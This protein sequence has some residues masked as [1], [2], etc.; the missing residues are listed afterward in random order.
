MLTVCSLMR[1]HHS[2][3]SEAEGGPARAAVHTQAAC[4]AFCCTWRHRGRRKREATWKNGENCHQPP[5]KTNHLLI[6]S[7]SEIKGG[8]QLSGSKHI[9]KKLAV[10]RWKILDISWSS[11][12]LPS[13]CRCLIVWGEKKSKS[14]TVYLVNK[15]LFIGVCFGINR[16]HKRSCV[17]KNKSLCAAQ[18]RRI[19]MPFHYRNRDRRA[20]PNTM[21][22]RV[23]SFHAMIRKHCRT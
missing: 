22:H 21:D 12:T 9:F 16:G 2:P 15:N 1:T 8:W 17:Q 11:E 5:K 6:P 19:L 18:Q 4:S 13:L 7:K 3:R 20:K 10:F 23:L 14:S